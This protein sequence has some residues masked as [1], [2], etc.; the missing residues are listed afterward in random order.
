MM[1]EILKLFGIGAIVLAICSAGAFATYHIGKYFDDKAL[2]EEKIES[3]EDCIVAGNSAMGSNP[4]RCID[5]DGNVFA[6]EI[7]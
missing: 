2:E 6:K 5:G 3:F 4:I 7:P 1:Y